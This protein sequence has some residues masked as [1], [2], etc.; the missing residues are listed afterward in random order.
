MPSQQPGELRCFKCGATDTESIVQGGS[1][2]LRCLTCHANVV[3]TSWMAVGP[4]WSSVVRVYRDGHDAEG[5][6]LEGVGSELWQRILKL[7]S[8]GSTLV[9]R[10]D[11]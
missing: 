4:Q 6:V 7:A 11:G 9:L 8:D 5:P 3:A 2:C 1:Y 10:A